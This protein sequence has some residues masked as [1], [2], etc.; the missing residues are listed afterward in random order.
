VPLP[1]LVLTALLCG[2]LVMVIEVL[3][4]RV[5]GPFFGVSLF[6]WT[7]L[8]TVT[9]VA[10]AAGYAAGGVI[11][12]RRGTPD[13][14]YGIVLAAGLLV[15]LVP[16]LRAP[17]LRACVPLG[18]RAGA[19]VASAI[20]F[21]PALFLLGC[22]SP[23]LVKIAAREMASL[24]RTVGTLYAISTVGSF[25][26]TLVTG[27]VLIAWFG[28][29]RIFQG[30]GALLVLLGAAWFVGFRRRWAALAALPLAL[31]SP[32]PASPVKVLE[33]GTRR[34]ERAREDTYYGSLRVVD[35]EGTS[36]R[37]RE[38]L[39]DGLVQ[40]G[41]D[42]ANGL[43]VHEYAYS[44]QYLPWSVRPGGRT[45]LVVGLG[46]GLVPRWYEAQGVR[47]DVVDI[48][49]AVVRLARTW[50]GFEV[51]G[52][53]FVDDARHFLGTTDRTYDYVV[54][55]VFNGD[56]TPGHVL[57]REA[58]GLAARRLAPGGVLAANVIGSLG[59]DRFMTASIVR[60]FREVFPVV[61]V[62]PVLLAETGLGNLTVLAWNDPTRRPDPSV[63]AGFEYHPIAAGGRDHLFRRFEFPAGERAVVL[64]D[65]Y[66]PIDVFDRWVKERLRERVLSY[67]DWDVLL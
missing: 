25:A 22:V 49:P 14:L 67:T 39:I 65:D 43:S 28:V 13:T 29:G 58:L 53:V 57:S 2:G 6:V 4:S 51:S 45:C 36:M 50:F 19:L 38:L 15:L 30:V 64:T 35:Y 9:L 23:L 59:E 12:D 56:T 46:A 17:V 10:L 20:L 5:I 66:G 52:D 27:F 60:T 1:F 8:I 63:V 18:L 31:L 47:T 7:S 34:I 11:S 37:V 21:G 48:D 41:I 24:G 26:G 33:N 3:G 42:V 40:G 55:D 62:Y 16:F 61:E 44:L 54:L 32:S